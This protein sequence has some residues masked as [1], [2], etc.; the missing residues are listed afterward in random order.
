MIKIPPKIYNCPFCK[1]EFEKRDAEKI[2]SNCF[3]CTGCEIF[4][5]PYCGKEVVFK[6]IKPYKP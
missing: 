2:C 6:P 1:T 3:A 5:C 4:Y